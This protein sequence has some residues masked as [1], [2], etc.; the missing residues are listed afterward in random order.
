MK[1]KKL[2]KVCVRKELI[3]KNLKK[4]IKFIVLFYKYLLM[5]LLDSIIYKF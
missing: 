4:K 1:E 2:L 5:Y 3:Q